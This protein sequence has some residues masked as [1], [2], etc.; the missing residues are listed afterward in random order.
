MADFDDIASGL[1]ANL[2]ALS[3]F[4]V[5]TEQLDSPSPPTI[6]VAGVEAVEY[7]VAFPKAGVTSDMW[8]V[9]IEVCLPRDTDRTP[10]RLL[11]KLLATAGAGSLKAAAES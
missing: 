1:A 10:Q 4:Q 8:L 2:A 11:R 7:D 5:A 3:G 9:Q 6:Q